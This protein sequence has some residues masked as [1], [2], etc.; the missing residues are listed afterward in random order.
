MQTTAH[1]THIHETIIVELQKARQS[2]YVAVAWFTDRALFQ[3]LCERAEAGVTVE[4][5]ITND[6]INFREG[7]L[8]FDMLRQAGGRVY[9]IGTDKESE[10]LMHN[11]FCV[12]DGQTVITGSFN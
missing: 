5:M 1:F 12:I 8:P 9:A 2:V 11:K 7:G 4:L 6:A 3:T 10:T